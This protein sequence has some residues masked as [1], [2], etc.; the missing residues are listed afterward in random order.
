MF[1]QILTPHYVY[2][3]KNAVLL[4]WGCPVIVPLPFLQA[5]TWGQPLLQ[6][7]AAWNKCGE[8]REVGRNWVIRVTKSSNGN[9]PVLWLLQ[10]LEVWGRWDTA[11]VSETEVGRLLHPFTR[12]LRSQRKVSVWTVKKETGS[13]IMSSIWSRY[14]AFSSSR[15]FPIFFYVII[16]VLN[17][18]L[19]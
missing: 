17:K 6:S 12:K 19:K 9:H 8:G 18:E 2:K 11:S 5:L 14:R 13:L 4:L 3:T 16:S 7:S 1:I 10:G 15:D